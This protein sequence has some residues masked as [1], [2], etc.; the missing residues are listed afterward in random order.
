MRQ[1]PPVVR[2]IRVCPQEAIPSLQ[3][4]FECTQWNVI[5][6][7]ATC[8]DH[9]DLQET[10]LGLINECIDD[11]TVRKTVKLCSTNNPW[12]SE[13]LRSLLS[14]RNAAFSSGDTEAYN[15]TRNNLK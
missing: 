9:V 8:D 13:E 11:V 5:K 3:G 6:E 10:V 7:A 2:D 1:E 14:L 15:V 4:C 12:L